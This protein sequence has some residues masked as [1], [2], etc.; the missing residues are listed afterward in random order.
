MFNALVPLRVESALELSNS[1]ESAA[2][3][4]VYTA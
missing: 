4:T 1:L 2:Q 3:A